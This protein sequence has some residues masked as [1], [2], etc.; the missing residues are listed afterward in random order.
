MAD[1]KRVARTAGISGTLV[2]S[3]LAET[4]E[5]PAD[6]VITPDGVEVTEAQWKVIAE[7]ATANHVV[8]RLDEDFP[9]TAAQDSAPEAEGSAATGGGE[10]K[11]QV[12]TQD[13]GTAVDGTE[14]PASSSTGTTARKGR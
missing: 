3:G 14:A 11:E 1:E 13:T 12:Q 7:A 2:M 6:L 10:S 5:G 9:V 8:V 4:D